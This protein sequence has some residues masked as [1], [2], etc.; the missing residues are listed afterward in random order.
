MKHINRAYNIVDQAVSIN[1]DFDKSRVE[2]FTTVRMKLFEKSLTQNVLQFRLCA[3][4]INIDSLE[5]T[6]LQMYHPETKDIKTYPEKVQIKNL[7][8]PT[9]ER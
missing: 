2:G 8:Y 9:P 6:N 7:N 4:Q 1:L 3:K 5:V